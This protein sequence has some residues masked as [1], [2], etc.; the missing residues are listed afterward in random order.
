[1][2]MDTQLR[3]INMIV[4]L[5]VCLLLSGCH[6]VRIERERS[7]VATL[8]QEKL[9]YTVPPSFSC[10]LENMIQKGISRDDAIRIALLNNPALQAD[11]ESIGIAKADFVQAGLFTN[12]TVEAG[13]WFPIKAEATQFGV[14]VGFALN[15]L[16]QIPLR[17]RVFKDQLDVAVLK[18]LS[19]VRT[20]ISS[21]IYA[22][23]TVL[24]I[25]EALKNSRIILSYIKKLKEDM[26]QREKF[27]LT[28]QADIATVDAAQG[29]REV[30]LLKLK[31]TLIHQSIEL[32]YLLGFSPSCKFV[33][34]DRLYPLCKDIPPV[35]E[36]ECWALQT[37]PEVL[38]AQMNVKVQ[39]D[40]VA[41]ERGQRIKAV[42]VGVSYARDF[43]T[44]TGIGPSIQGSVPLFDDNQAQ[45]DKA[46]FLLKK[47]QKELC[48]EQ[49]RVIK[50]VHQAYEVVKSIQRQINRYTTK[51][52][53]LHKKIVGF[54]LEFTPAMQVTIPTLLQNRIAHYEAKKSL[55]ALKFEFAKAWTDL[56]KAVSK[57]I[58]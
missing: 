21:V 49:S 24:Y 41:L 55:L 22:Y 54:A 37:R 2:P 9:G 6:R 48:M 29:E 12:P 27:G 44:S 5:F 25:Q 20:L 26:Q 15:D 53:P 1:M 46:E 58:C 16:W 28:T 36:L 52:L 30:E 42:G 31:S 4:L 14:S 13:W 18:V 39:E 17:K 34:T 33:L 10:S 43:D 50:E 11:F 51:I 32:R 8:T 23:D 3:K 19:S 56:E 7:H 35:Q 40:L 45:I 38:I 47:A 57:R